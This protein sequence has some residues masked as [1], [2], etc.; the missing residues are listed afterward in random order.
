MCETAAEGG[1]G[2]FVSAACPRLALARLPEIAKAIVASQ[3][4]SGRAVGAALC[5]L[6][7]RKM[8]PM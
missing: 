6:I 3:L 7:S 5:K 8:R 1:P 2:L 4:S